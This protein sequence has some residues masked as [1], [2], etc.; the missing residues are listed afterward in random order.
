MIYGEKQYGI[1]TRELSKLR[2]ALAAVQA[3]DVDDEWVQRLEIDALKSQIAELEADIAHYDLLKAGEIAVTKSFSLEALPSILIQA[4]IATGMSQ[5]ELAAALGVKP[6]Q[7]QRYEASG[8]LGASLTR[9]IEVSR[10][11]NVHTAGLF[12]AQAPQEGGVFSWEKA[13]DLVWQ[14]L[15]AREMARRRWFDVPRGAD[16]I[17]RAK[18]YFLQAAGPQFATALHRK[19]LRGSTQPNEYALLAWQAR[20]LER[21]RTRI[22]G[23]VLPTFTLDD[24]WL[25]ELVALTR[26]KNGPRRVRNL[27]ARK[28]IVLVTEEHLPGTFLDGAAMLMDSDHPVIGMTLRYDRLDNFWFVLFHELGHVFLHLLEGVRYDFFDEEGIDGGD[29]VECEA[30]QFALASLIPDAAW[31]QCLS[32]FA[33]SEEAVRLD[34]EALGIDVSI[35]AGRIR[36]EQ[37]NY[38]I[39]TNLVGHELVRTQFVEAEDDLE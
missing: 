13:D 17:E 20:V 19:K 33:L 35:I 27:L 8:Y 21:A 25:P 16:L 36:K 4:R 31:D 29:R 28:G 12:E 10:I 30:D 34:A 37:E 3:Q 14:Q 18:T 6:Q 32:R 2:D 22:T 11:L 24:R 26:H 39:L 9:L 15:P 23:D 1:S 5:T 7:V 38:T